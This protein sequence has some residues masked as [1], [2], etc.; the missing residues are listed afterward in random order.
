M[1]CSLRIK[2]L[3]LVEDLSLDF[4]GGFTVLTGE[5]GAGKSLLV[6]ALALLLGARA[7][8][9]V[10]RAGTDRATVEAVVDGNF[11]SWNALLQD[12]GLPMEQP[13][14]LRREVGTNG[15]SRAWVNGASVTLTDLREASRIWVRLTS[16]H[17][18][19]SLLSEER[20]LGLFDEIIGIEADLSK[21]AAAVKDAES[22]LSARKRSEADRERRLGEL[23]ELLATLVKFSP[24][25]HEWSQLRAER[26]PLRHA[27]QL[28]AAW[29]D[30]AE[31]FRQAMPHFESAQRAVT[32][33]ALILPEMQNEQDRMRS[34]LI[35]LEDLSARSEDEYRKWAS[36]GESRLEEVEGRLAKYERFARRLG[37]EPDELAEKTKQLQAEQAQLM[38]GES[39]ITELE[40]ALEGAVKVYCDAAL[41]LHDKRKDA[42][43]GLEKKVHKHLGRLGMS[44]AKLQIRIG[45]HEDEK[46]V[47][48]HQGHGVRV[49]PKGFTGVTLWIEP[50]VGEG[51]RPLAKIA[52]GGE[53]SRLM[54]AMMSA[55]KGASDGLTLILDEVDAGLGGETALA[56]GESVKELGQRHQVLAVTH[57]AQV[58]SRANHHGVLQKETS[59]GRTRTTL[60]WINGDLQIRELARLLSGHPDGP[61]AQA[62]AKS[63]LSGG[64][65]RNPV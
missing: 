47:V 60:T 62:H 22:R 50:N 38:E 23:E 13:I 29:K 19:Q 48:T 65:G 15:R 34:A 7:D 63:L 36:K 1:L 49:S 44:G 21:E 58:A 11:D 42:V 2:N 27:T 18:H 46:S 35:E 33:V 59:D 52:S 53:L 9:E 26:E 31:G 17:D 37:C 39:S 20:H 61:E 41:E 16:Q 24:K 10:V 25:P 3:A 14:V 12:R 55:G 6:D 43:S 64:S 32:R 51:F 45:L 8:T 28:E 54:L 40:K 5:T 30:A 57:L 4:E 56:V